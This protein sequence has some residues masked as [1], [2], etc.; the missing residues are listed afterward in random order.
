MKSFSKQ[1]SRY[2]VFEANIYSYQKFFIGFLFESTLGT[3]TDHERIWFTLGLIWYI[4]EIGV[5]DTRH[6]KNPSA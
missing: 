3:K 6:A 5:Y 4:I 1:V 2:K